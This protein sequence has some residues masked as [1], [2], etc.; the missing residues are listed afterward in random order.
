MPDDPSLR[1]MTY[2]I[3][4]GRGLDGRV[5]LGRIAAV[6]EAH[7]PDVVA[8]QEVDAF[9]TRSGATDQAEDLARRLGMEARFAPCIV[10]GDERYGIATLSRRPLGEHRQVCLP[11]GAPAR[12][13]E[14][15]CA[16]VTRVTWGLREVDVINTHL[17]LRRGERSAQ[18]AALTRLEACADLVLVGDLNCTPGAP[19]FRALL[20]HLRS[21]PWAQATWP[22][23]WPILRL[24]HVLYRGA[25][26]A[27]GAVVVGSREARRASD[28]LPVL[29]TF[30]DAATTSGGG[31]PS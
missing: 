5:D 17:S 19:P 9:R 23:R 4:H 24:D 25:L 11:Q 8:L 26:A 29:A 10:T 2:N 6:I 20:D 31:T 7:A 12:F 14:P 16:L 22:S 28:H 30:E 18:L 3:R 1:V 13:S 27:A 21:T 15:R